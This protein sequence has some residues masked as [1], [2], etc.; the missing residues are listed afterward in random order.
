VVSGSTK[1]NTV[2]RHQ[3][4]K[5]LNGPAETGLTTNYLNYL[6]SVSKAHGI[7]FSSAV[8][9]CTNNNNFNIINTK[10]KRGR[11]CY[12]CSSKNHLSNECPLKRT[13]NVI[14]KD[15]LS[16]YQSIIKGHYINEMMRDVMPYTFKFDKSEFSQYGEV[17]KEIALQKIKDKHYKAYKLSLNNKIKMIMKD[18]RH[19]YNMPRK[20]NGKMFNYIKSL[21]KNFTN[22]KIRNSIKYDTIVEVEHEERREVKRLA[23]KNKNKRSHARR[24]Y[25]KLINE[26][27]TNQAAKFLDDK[28]ESIKQAANDLDKEKVAELKSEIEA[29]KDLTTFEKNAITKVEQRINQSSVVRKVIKGK[30]YYEEKKAKKKKATNVALKSTIKTDSHNSN[31]SEFKELHSQEYQLL[32]SKKILDMTPEECESILKIK[33]EVDES[34]D[35]NAKMRFKMVEDRYSFF[36]HINYYKVKEVAQAKDEAIKKDKEF[37][38]FAKQLILENTETHLANICLAKRIYPDNR[39][40]QIEYLEVLDKVAADMLVKGDIEESFEQATKKQEQSPADEYYYN[41]D[42]ECCYYDQQDNYDD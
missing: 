11:K 31:P 24:R 36:V 7:N 14:N 1:T 15:G 9:Q 17:S 16:K 26:I 18:L 20:Y 6:L 21:V 39:Q 12:I 3:A 41:S 4:T 42:G 27:I 33:N 10:N 30:V 29:C 28:F 5:S 38:H 22:R 32:I 19:K 13:R 8:L 2:K 40:Y 34:C 37:K 35:L 25:N 23:K